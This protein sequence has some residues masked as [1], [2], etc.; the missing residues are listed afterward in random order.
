MANHTATKKSIRKTETVTA[1]RRSRKSRVK[2]YISKLD[3][4]ISSGDKKQAQE[5]LRTAEAQIMKAVSK[6]VF[7]LRSASRKVSRLCA[8]V[9]AMA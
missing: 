1:R 8:K 2:S 5:A 9:K 7:K 3:A 6:G 4:A